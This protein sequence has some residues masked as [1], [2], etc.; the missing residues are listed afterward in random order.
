MALKQLF[1]HAIDS[2]CG[3]IRVQQVLEETNHSHPTQI[4]AIGKAASAMASGA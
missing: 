3:S 2:A 1:D 4:I